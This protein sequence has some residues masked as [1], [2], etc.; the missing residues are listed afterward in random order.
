MALASTG[1]LPKKSSLIICAV[2]RIILVRG[3]LRNHAFNSTTTTGIYQYFRDNDDFRIVNCSE[4]SKPVAA[5]VSET[6]FMDI[7]GL[8]DLWIGGS[9]IAKNLTEAEIIAHLEA[10][11]RFVIFDG[12]DN[13]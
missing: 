9:L 2:L 10:D 3:V 4:Y 12:E 8:H 7:N 6:N 13:V 1:S 5:P 11:G